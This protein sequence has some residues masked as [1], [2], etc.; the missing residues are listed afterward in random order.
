MMQEPTYTAG[1]IDE[2]RF[3]LGGDAQRIRVWRHRGQHQDERFVVTRPE[4]LVSLH[5]HPYRTICRNCVRMF[6]LHGMDYHRTPL[7]TST[8]PYRDVWC[9]LILVTFIFLPNTTAL[10]HF[11]LGAKLP[12]IRHADVP[13]KVATE[14]NYRVGVSSKVATKWNYKVGVSSKV[15]TDW[16]YRVGVSSKVATEWNYKVGVSNKVAT[17]WNYKV[18]VS[19]K[20]A[21]E[22]NYKVGVSSKVATEWNYRVGVSNEM[23]TEWNYRVGVSSKVATEWNY[24]VGVSNK[25]ATEWNY[26][27]GVSSK[28]ASRE[29]KQHPVDVLEASMTTEQCTVTLQA[30]AGRESK[31]YPVA[32]TEILEAGMIPEQCTVTLQ[33]DRI[34]QPVLGSPD[35]QS[36]DGPF[37]PIPQYHL[38]FPS[39][40][41]NQMSFFFESRA[42]LNQAEALT[43]FHLGPEISSK[44]GVPE[45]TKGNPPKERQNLEDWM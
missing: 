43:M 44:Y 9:L 24:K 11:L 31:Q 33:A 45:R 8:A 38:A 21:S 12:G 4:G 5:L 36:E 20:M 18:G 19:S 37:P 35:L 34:S 1:L 41:R 2:S 16:S 10:P 25:V 7:G 14:W 6:K 3:S 32:P 13:I 26:K 28:M 27:V 23:A 29:S 39:L 30:E 42:A 17:E 22:W 15:A 40:Q